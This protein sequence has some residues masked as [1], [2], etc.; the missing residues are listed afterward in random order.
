MKINE[1]KYFNLMYEHTLPK[2]SNES[3]HDWVEI[4]R[5]DNFRSGWHEDICTH[6]GLKVGYDTSD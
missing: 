3:G 5:P 4:S 6:C 1:N 2:C